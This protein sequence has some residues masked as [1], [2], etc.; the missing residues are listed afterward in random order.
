MYTYLRTAIEA[1]ID[2]ERNRVFRC[3]L[4]VI[5]V[6]RLPVYMG[7]RKFVVCIDHLSSDICAP[8]SPSSALR[9][10]QIK[11]VCKFVRLSPPS[12][13]ACGCVGSHPMTAC[14]VMECRATGPER[15]ACWIDGWTVLGRALWS[16]TWIPIMI[17][18]SPSASAQCHQ[19]TYVH[20]AVNIRQFPTQTSLPRDTAITRHS[21][22]LA[23]SH[24]P[25]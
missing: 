20:A 1:E 5:L 18:S 2:S 6:E 12:Q 16:T 9:A 24:S 3:G 10:H 21:S 4:R 11:C 14:A 7:R 23:S 8:P 19:L 22:Y 13:P 15:A 17:K 25:K